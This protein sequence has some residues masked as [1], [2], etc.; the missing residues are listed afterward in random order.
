VSKPAKSNSGRRGGGG[1]IRDDPL[2]WLTEEPPAAADATEVPEAAEAPQAPQ[3]SNVPDAPDTTTT[4]A[5]EPAQPAE[6]DGWGLF[7]S[8]AQ[9][10]GAA[11]TDSQTQAETQADTQADTAGEGWGLFDAGGPAA[12]ADA[13]SAGEGWGLFAPSTPAPAAQGVAD[14]VAKDGSWGL[15]AVP[16]DAQR[17]KLGSSLLFAD[18]NSCYQQLLG[19]SE[20]GAVSVEGRAVERIDAAGLQLLCALQRSERYHGRA[21][22]WAGAS[23]VLLRGAADLGLVEELGLAAV[24]EAAA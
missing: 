1:I 10:G 6:G 3:A 16:R 21:V 23:A 18:V 2:A 8:A 24:V 5:A 19:A 9:A 20:R 12:D 17:I 4:A 22:H 14:E 11:Q 13:D 7:D 15:F